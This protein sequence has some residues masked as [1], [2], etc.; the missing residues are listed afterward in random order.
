[1]IKF[2]I[3]GL[4]VL[5]SI[6]LIILIVKCIKGKRFLIRQF[7]RCNCI[8]FGK[9]GTGKDLLFNAVINGRKKPC[10]ANI[11]YNEKF[12]EVKQIKDFSVSPNTYEN[13]LNDDIKV[14]DKKNEKKD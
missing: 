14:I 11:P 12:C 2:I 4:L 5:S 8:V 7:E 6:A 13:F 3:I 10:Y 1:M 9:K